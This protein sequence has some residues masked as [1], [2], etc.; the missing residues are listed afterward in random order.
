MGSKENMLASLPDGEPVITQDMADKY[1]KAVKEQRIKNFEKA[2]DSGAIA[3]PNKTGSG[4]KKKSSLGGVTNSDVIG[5]AGAEIPVKPAAN[6]G[7]N[8]ATVAI[9]SDRNVSWN[10]VGKI[11]KGYN[12]VTKENA[13][14]WLTRRHVREATPEEVAS[15]YGA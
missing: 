6:A 4:K 10:G 14:K 11:E 5:T 13:A 12:I 7:R 9:Y 1:K 15:E 3:A 2:K 8:K